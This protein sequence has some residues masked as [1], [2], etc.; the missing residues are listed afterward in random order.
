MSDVMKTV[1]V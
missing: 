1:H